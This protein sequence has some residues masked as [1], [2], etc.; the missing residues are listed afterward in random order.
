MNFLGGGGTNFEISI[1]Y[2]NQERNLCN[3]S[4]KNFKELV[5]G[6]V[7]IIFLGS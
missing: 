3:F 1:N 7:L 5:Y 2:K 6:W 4:D